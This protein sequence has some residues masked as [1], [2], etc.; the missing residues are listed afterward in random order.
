MQQHYFT[1]NATSELKDVYFYQQIVE[2]KDKLFFRSPWSGTFIRNSMPDG[3]LLQYSKESEP[4]HF[5]TVAEYEKY[6]ET[7]NDHFW[8]YLPLKIFCHND[9]FYGV[10]VCSSCDQMR[11]TMS[12][13]IQQ[14][15][16]DIIPRLCAHSK[17]S[18][19]I[20]GDWRNIPEWSDIV[21][22]TTGQ[23]S[24]IQCNE[25]ITVH[26]FQCDPIGL[27][28]AAVRDTSGDIAML[29]TVTPRQST[30]VCSRCT[31]RGC[32]HYKQYTK[33][34]AEMQNNIQPGNEEAIQAD[35]DVV[36]HNE[37]SDDDDDDTE[38][39]QIGSHA[40]YWD[41]LPKNEHRKLYGHNFAKIPYPIHEDK[42]F[43]EK[44]LKRLKGEFD[45]PSVLKPEY[46]EGET[47]LHKRPFDETDDNLVKVSSNIKVYHQLGEEIIES[48]VFARPTIGNFCLCTMNVDG[49]PYLIW[50]LGK[51]RF[52]DYR[53]LYSNLQLWCEGGT[54]MYQMWKAIRNTTRQSNI[55][56]TL[57]YSD[58]HRSFTEFV[59]NIEMDWVRAFSCPV[60]GNSPK[61]MVFDG[62]NV[63]PL[64]RKVEH[65]TELISAPTDSTVLQKST[66]P[67]QRVFLTKKSEIKFIVN[68]LTEKTSMQ[69]FV[70]TAEITSANGLLIIDLVRHILVNFH[71][72]MPAPY[73]HLIENISK[74]TSARAL[75]Q[76]L[77]DEPLQYLKQYC[78]QELN[79]RS[80]QS[81][82]QLK[83][84]EDSFPAIWPD[85]DKICHLED[86]L[87]LPRALSAII[88][89]L[90]DIRDEMFRTAA[91]R[92]SSD[93]VKWPAYKEHP[94]MC[95]PALPLWRFP[96]K[97]EPELQEVRGTAV[98]STEDCR[99][100]F[101]K[102]N[103]FSGG[104]F[105]VGCGCKHSITL[106]FELM[107]QDE[108]P[109]NL[110]RFLQ[111][112]DV[113]MDSL[114]GIIVD[115]ACR[116][117]S[118][119]LNRE[120]DMLKNKLL[121]VD[122]AHWEGMKKLK[123]PDSRSCGHLGCCSSFNFNI[124]KSHICPSPNSESREQIH[125][126]IE[127]CTE[128]LRL[129]NYR[130]FMIFMRVFLAMKNLE[131][132]NYVY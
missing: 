49:T 74:P 33:H 17:V 114:K 39:E 13:S 54:K 65:L 25:D 16:A 31:R 105:S 60:E 86:Q 58:I 50:N 47:C 111:C 90:L 102:H 121:L 64:L 35:V 95:Y 115:N 118:Y 57:K 62:K 106:G 119:I 24:N 124:F 52:I 66:K 26:N 29:Y 85:L 81:Q 43:Q 87:Y 9:N 61:F 1:I 67:K 94:T 101:Q 123:Q 99:K 6:K 41:P 76:T 112:R 77:S 69:T 10:F 19:T 14:D 113:D 63:G 84:I 34:M 89:K 22:P 129:M 27:L 108:G 37:V 97:Y 45:I 30:P 5:R 55:I 72:N 42:E 79:L 32:L 100:N 78:N 75:L 110:F 71:T 125:S 82:Q 44:W 132:R 18:Q 68:L 2:E 127:K 73:K 23:M 3:T 98:N 21:V 88:L 48:S 126:L 12:L 131:K 96:S 40:N 80:P 120:A 130:H 83:S 103:T 8:I 128:S 122:G 93:Y 70:E 7:T 56:C 46:V 51:G 4:G 107:L 92:Q 28:L 59:N 104:L 91:Q 11:G 20:I 15:P 38:K 53:L 117:D 116:V 109:K 36:D